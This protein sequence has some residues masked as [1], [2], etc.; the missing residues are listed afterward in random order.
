MLISFEQLMPFIDKSVHGILHVGAHLC[1]ELQ[2]YKKILCDDIIWIEA[3]PDTY[4]K[5]KEDN[6]EQLIYNYLIT[7]EDDIYVP[8]NVANNNES[9][10]IF[11]FGTHEVYHSDINSLVKKY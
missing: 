5:A 8:F 1:E 4:L 6:P 9:S 2:S 10:S 11:D 3:D 7:D